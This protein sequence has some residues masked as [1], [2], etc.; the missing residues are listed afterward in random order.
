MRHPWPRRRL[1]LAVTA[2]A[3]VVAAGLPAVPASAGVST[4]AAAAFSVTPNTLL[5]NNQLVTAAGTGYPAGTQIGIVQCKTDPGGPQGCD[6]SR[7]DYVTSDGAGAFS[8]GYQVKRVIRVG[9]DSVDCATAGACIVGAGVVP[10]GVPAANAAI[11][12]D[13]SQP[14][15]PP[16]SLAVAPNTDLV[17]RQIVTVTGGGFDPGAGVGVIQCRTGAGGAEDCDFNTLRFFPADPD[18]GF[19]S[20]F[21]VRRL[22]RVGTETIDCAQPDA[23]EIGAGQDPTLG[24]R[25]PISFDPDAPLAPPPVAS[26]TP[27]TGLSDGQRVDVTGAGWEPNSGIY[28][29]QCKVGGPDDGSSCDL[30]SLITAPSDATGSFTTTF[31]VQAVISTQSGQVDCA[32]ASGTCM[33]AVVW[34]PDPGTAVTTPLSFGD[35]PP[36]PDGGPGSPPGSTPLVTPKFTG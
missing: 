8:V 4:P 33:I 26:V 34:P 17:D 14:L 6:L 18:G 10:D 29:I 11:Q 23:C 15:P 20:P 25:A 16:P 5:L 24:A 36:P 21:T 32:A 7:L 19:S 22:I 31:E 9:T 2:V 1:A 35:D 30:D 28:V 12:F 27:S 13:P 3:L